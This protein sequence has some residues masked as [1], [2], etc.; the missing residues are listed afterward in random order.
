MS[1][2][3]EIL[4]SGGEGLLETVKYV[5]AGLSVGLAALGPGVGEGYAAGKAAA[6]IA[7]QPA[8]AGQTL[9]T[10]L[11]GQAISE[12]SGI[13]G[14]VI[15]FLL[16]ATDPES[17]TNWAMGSA[18]LAA[19]LCMGLSAVGSAVG[20]G[21]V[22]GE[23]VSGIARMPESRSRV[24]LA[25][26]I[27]QALAQNGAILGFVVT[28]L[29]LGATQTVGI[30]STDWAGLLPPMAAFL[31]AGIAM[32]AGANGPSVGIGYVGAEACA[33]IARNLK[34]SALIQRTMFIGSAV[35]SSTSIYSLV[36][37]LLL[38]SIGG[39]M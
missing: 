12:T 26:L 39:R 23:A 28:I 11:I 18:M 17:I 27:S 32:G 16:I 34:D 20:A 1:E 33:G 29:L 2:W 4:A 13:F 14:L 38:W 6:G 35:A 7:R 31:G 37:A 30:D 21:L 5:A 36:V 8:E 9:R 24:T 22:A 3:E 19:G 10:M 25:M 15:A